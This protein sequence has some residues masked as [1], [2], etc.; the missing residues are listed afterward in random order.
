M[1]HQTLKC[2]TIDASC[3]PL[4]LCRLNIT[5][6]KSDLL[7]SQTTFSTWKLSLQMAPHLELIHSKVQHIATIADGTVQGIEDIL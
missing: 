5:V 2:E 6:E 4:Q 7:Q 3:C 1:H